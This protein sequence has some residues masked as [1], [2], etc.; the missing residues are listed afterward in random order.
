VKTLTEALEA[1]HGIRFDVDVAAELE[2][3]TKRQMFM[4]ERVEKGRAK[5]AKASKISKRVG[6]FVDA[7][8]LVEPMVDAVIQ[9]TPHA[10]PAALPWAGVCVGLQVSYRLD[11]LASVSA[12]TLR[13]SRTLRRRQDPTLPA[14]R[15]SFPGWI[16]TAP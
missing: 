13:S 7:A 10:A 16:G 11:R 6:D 1:E 8:L 14:S 2:D 3:P 9:N 5:V 15:P 12:D 4:R